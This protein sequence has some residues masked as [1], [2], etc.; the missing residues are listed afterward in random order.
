MAFLEIEVKRGQTVL[1]IALQQYGNVEGIDW[2][3]Q[4][5]PTL[6]LHSVAEGDII[7]IRKE[8][9]KDKSIVQYY[10]KRAYTPTTT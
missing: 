1:D 3:L 4:D 7:Q 5:N 10:N 6:Q 8:T 9:Y 2:I